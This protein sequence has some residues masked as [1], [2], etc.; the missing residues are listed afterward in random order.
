MKTDELTFAGRHQHP[1]TNHSESRRRRKQKEKKKRGTVNPR[2]GKGGGKERYE[3]AL[4]GCLALL[5][6]FTVCSALLLL[7]ALA[8]CGGVKGVAGAV[9]R[10][11]W[12]R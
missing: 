11:R 6:L 2:A 3:A 7:V 1:S 4:Y 10:T 9:T 5:T 8:R 12:K